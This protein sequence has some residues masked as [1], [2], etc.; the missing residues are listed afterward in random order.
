MWPFNRST[1]LTRSGVLSGATDWH[2][3]LLPGVDD[4]SP[5]MA[6]SLSAL[7]R[8]EQAGFRKIWL[9]PHIMEEIPNTTSG[10]RS[11]FEELR[12]Q[13]NGNLE[14]N[15]GSEN[16]LDS[17]FGRRLEEGDL[18]PLGP[19]GD[20]LLVET[21]FAAVPWGFEDLL[22]RIRA[23]GY[24]PVLAHPERYRFLDRD[25]LEELH[26]QGT[27]FQVN[28]LSLTGFY[29]KRAMQAAVWL[30]K[31]GLADLAGS[32]LHRAAQWDAAETTG[33]AAGSARLLGAI[34][35]KEDCGKR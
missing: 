21:S 4:G 11:R 3:H 5:T 6:E 27:L 10:L 2:S 30:L 26:A 12:S 34:M 20:K 8:L 9:T 25:D 32:D 7:R 14:L 28:F 24:F 22:G 31:K 16:M 1:T 33:M 17:L 35:G 19:R 13:W 15:L 23:K 18:L 29:G